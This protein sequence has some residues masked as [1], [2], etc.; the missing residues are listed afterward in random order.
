M[1][2]TVTLPDVAPIPLRRPTAVLTPKGYAVLSLIRE[3]DALDA[4]DAA[5][6]DRLDHEIS[7]LLA[8]VG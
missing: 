3:Q 2:A 7:E 1:H 4:G 8:S 6:R 5:G